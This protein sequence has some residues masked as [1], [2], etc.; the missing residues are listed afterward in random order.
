MNTVSTDVPVDHVVFYAG[1]ELGELASF[2]ERIGFQL[3]PLGR[4]SSGSINRLAMLEGQYIELMGFEPGTPRTVRPELQVLPLGL[5][6]IVAADPAGRVRRT[7]AEGFNPPVHLERPVDT[8]H[9]KGLASFTITTVRDSA[10]DARTFMCRHHTPHLVW[11][12]AWQQ[13]PNGATRVSE[14]RLPTRDPGKLRAAVRTIFDIPGDGDAQA[15]DA[16]GTCVR[17]VPQDE[18]GVLTVR[19]RELRRVVDVLE[20]AGVPHSAAEDGSVVVALPAPYAA[21]VVFQAGA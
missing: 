5:N 20:R 8:P 17:V 9:A 21:D 14:V 11:H 10:A 15:I 16:A 1:Y 6:G 3:T 12:E 18:R 13:H 7:G 19:T 4:H 2:M